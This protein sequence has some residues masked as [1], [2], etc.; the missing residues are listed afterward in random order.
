MHDEDLFGIHEDVLTESVKHM[1]ENIVCDL[2]QSILE[3]DRRT[4]LYHLNRL[5]GR[6]IRP[7]VR[8]E[9]RFLKDDTDWY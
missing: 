9:I 7:A 5:K 8:Q 3:G 4:A 2:E 6:D 1:F